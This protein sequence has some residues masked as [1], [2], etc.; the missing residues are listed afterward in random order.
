MYSSILCED[1]YLDGELRKGEI[2]K[3]ICKLKNIKTGG[4]DGLVG[5]LAEV[6]GSRNGTCYISFSKLYGMKKP[7][8]SSGGRG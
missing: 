8:L 6:W 1:E 5:G 3:C 7:Y 4:S 2:E